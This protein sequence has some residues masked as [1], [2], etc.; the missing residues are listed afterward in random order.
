MFRTHMWEPVKCTDQRFFFWDLEECFNR[1]PHW[2]FRY[3]SIPVS[4]F[5][6]FLFQ[7]F[8]QRIRVVLNI[9]IPL[10][11]L[12]RFLRL[13]LDV[14]L[15]ILKPHAI[16][17]FETQ[18]SLSPPH[19]TSFTIWSRYWALGLPLHLSLY[20]SFRQVIMS[21]YVS[22]HCISPLFETWTIPASHQPSWAS[23]H[24]SF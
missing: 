20:Y 7:F 16:S 12:E 22:N 17:L 23:P 18:V 6:W 9:Y 8:R 21:Q 11:D 3:H 1:R 14:V 4:F 10:L 2:I 15:R 5:V 19:L 24:L 13:L